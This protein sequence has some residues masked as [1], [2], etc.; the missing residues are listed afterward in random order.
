MT[1]LKPRDATK[2]EWLSPDNSVSLLID[3]QPTQVKISHSM[4]RHQLSENI[5]AGIKLLKKYQ[6]PNIL[7]TVNVSDW[8]DLETIS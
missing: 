3:Y 4:D 2:D 7:S 8:R 1:S 5:I 6:L